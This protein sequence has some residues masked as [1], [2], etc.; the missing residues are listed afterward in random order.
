M[1]AS[2]LAQLPAK[3]TKD[4]VV[5]IAG[6]PRISCIGRLKTVINA[7]DRHGKWIRA[8]FSDTIPQD[9]IPEKM[10]LAL[11]LEGI[12]HPSWQ[13]VVSAA[14]RSG[15]C[16]P[17]HLFKAGEI[18]SVLAILAARRME[19]NGNAEPPTEIESADGP[20][21]PE[22]SPARR[23]I[24]VAL[25]TLEALRPNL[26]LGLISFMTAADRI[27]TLSTENEAL[28]QEV[29]AMRRSTDKLEERV[30]VMRGFRKERDLLRI[31]SRAK[32]AEIGRM[33]VTLSQVETSLRI[34]RRQE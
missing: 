10:T 11:V 27:E 31:S 16:A 33:E 18:A 17:N 14:E 15:A 26:E 19:G 4:D 23:E 29:V 13:N 5:F 7:L 34:F 2:I 32:D 12:P 24:D 21:L 30:R 25:A 6:G 3:F 28:R 1:D 20:I 9:S 22:V 8:T